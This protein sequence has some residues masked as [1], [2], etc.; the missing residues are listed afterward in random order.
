MSLMH[1]WKQEASEGRDV[2]YFH[3]PAT[4]TKEL[5][6]KGNLPGEGNP[7]RTFVQKTPLSNQTRNALHGGQQSI[8][9]CV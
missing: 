9:R 3:V 2:A 7:Q 5:G 6:S 1:D 8:D 4:V